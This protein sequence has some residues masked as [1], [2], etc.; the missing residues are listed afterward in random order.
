MPQTTPDNGQDLER[1]F[2]V[3]AA[4]LL[5]VGF[6]DEQGYYGLQHTDGC[7]VRPTVE[8]RQLRDCGG[9]TFHGKHHFASAGRCPKNLD[10]PLEDQEYPGARLAFPKEHF[11]GRKSPFHRSSGQLLKLAFAE[12]REQGDF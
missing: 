12:G 1:D 5:K 8:Q 11:F 6:V 3:L 2:R 4:E 7:R 9:R 10:T